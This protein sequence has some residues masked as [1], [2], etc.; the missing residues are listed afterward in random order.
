MV[1]F[2]TA[3]DVANIRIDNSVIATN[4]FVGIGVAEEILTALENR[5]LET[6]SPKNLELYF[7]AGQGIQR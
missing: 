5:Y 4:G 3:K 1:E 6:K 2:C 7:A